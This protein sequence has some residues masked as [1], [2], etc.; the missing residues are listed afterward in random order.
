MAGII[1]GIFLVLV[2][3]D[4]GIKQYIDDSWKE[5]E[6]RETLIPRLVLRKVYNRGFALNALEKRPEIVRGVSGA[7]CL[8]VFLYDLW[9]FLQKGKRLR[10]LGMAL[11]SAGAVSNTYDRLVRRKVIDYIGFCTKIQYLSQ[12]TANLAD[13]YVA[14]GTALVSLCNVGKKKKR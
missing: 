14:A 10:K 12:L 8:W 3:L 13:F 2:C 6:E 4:M 11:V 9:L 1:G 5:G 7:A